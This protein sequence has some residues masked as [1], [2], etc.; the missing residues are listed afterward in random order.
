MFFLSKL[1]LSIIFLGDS[2]Q[3]DECYCNQLPVKAYNLCS[4]FSSIFDMKS[5][6]IDFRGS[7]SW[8]LE[9]SPQFA[10]AICSMYY[11]KM[12]SLK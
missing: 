6:L 1:N 2:F 7:F 11:A 5:C 3:I 8:E 4:S 12:L 10:D 9:K